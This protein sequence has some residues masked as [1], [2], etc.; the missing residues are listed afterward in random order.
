MFMKHM[1]SQVARA[2]RATFDVFLKHL[3]DKQTRYGLL[4]SFFLVKPAEI[5]RINNKTTLLTTEMKAST[6]LTTFITYDDDDD[7]ILSH[8]VSTVSPL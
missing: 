3:E 6:I 4:L 5:T 1:S 7:L 8:S 2:Q